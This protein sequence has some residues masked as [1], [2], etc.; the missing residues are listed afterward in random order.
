MRRDTRPFRKRELGGGNGEEMIHRLNPA[1][2]EEGCDGIKTDGW[3]Q[4]TC[5]IGIPHW[6][7]SSQSPRY[8]PCYRRVSLISAYRLPYPDHSLALPGGSARSS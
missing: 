4:I 1:R 5:L 6:D 2:N 7:A 3:A 8:V